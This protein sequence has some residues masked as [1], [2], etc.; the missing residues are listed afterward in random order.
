M[1][2]NS[3]RK[4]ERNH[5]IAPFLFFSSTNAVVSVQFLK[6]PSFRKRILWWSEMF[7]KIL[8]FHTY[9]FVRFRCGITEYILRNNRDL[10]YT[11]SGF[12]FLFLSRIMKFFIPLRGLRRRFQNCT[13]SIYNG[14]SPPVISRLRFRL[15]AAPFS[16]PS[17]A[18][19]TI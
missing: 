19:P 10:Q 18:R 9:I 14:A 2:L 5:V 6:P 17:F 12:N 16:V 13:D 1:D 4:S 15:P 7:Q 8:L 3:R 11:S